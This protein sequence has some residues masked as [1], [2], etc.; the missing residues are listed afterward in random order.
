MLDSL[1][2]TP[3]EYFARNCYVGA[4]YM[5]AN[6]VQ[7]RGDMGVDRVMWGSDYPHSEGT[8]PFSREAIR[9]AFNGV[10]TDEI[11]LMLGETAMQLYRLNESALKDAASRF[12]PTV[13]EIASPVVDMPDAPCVVFEAT[14]PVRAW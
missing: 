5:T 2:L 14:D 13:E 8:Y 3:S 4:S 6:E 11:R 10:P 12:G 7:M 1:Q 9:I